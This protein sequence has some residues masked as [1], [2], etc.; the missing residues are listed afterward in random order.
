[1]KQFDIY[2]NPD[3]QSARRRP[4]LVVLQSELLKV[5]DTV[6]VAPMAPRERVQLVPRLMPTVE[7][8]GVDY[9]ILVH[10]LA[11]IARAQLKRPIGTAESER[12]ALLA[13]IDLVFVGF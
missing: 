1:M 12:D 2:R 5:I 13:A 8:S 11:A 3:L 9:A 10:E 7:V 6:V 4:Y